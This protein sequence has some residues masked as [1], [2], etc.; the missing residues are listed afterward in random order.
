MNGDILKVIKHLEKEKGVEREN[1]FQAIESALLTASKKKLGEDAETEVHIDRKTGEISITCKEEKITLE[2]FGRVA[3][4]TAKQVMIQKIREAEKDMVFQEFKPTEGA[5]LSGMVSRFEH[6]NVILTVGKTEAILPYSE[7]MP[8]EE[9][10]RGA[11]IKVYVLEVKKVGRGPQLVV[12]RS[13]S[14]MIKRLFELEVPE[15]KEGVVEIKSVAREPGN[16]TKICVHSKMENVD[17]VGACV[18]VKGARIKNII[19]ELG[20]EKIDIIPWSEDYKVYI[21]NALNPA[22]ILDIKINKK[23]MSTVVSVA[24]EQL[25]LAIGK[26]GQN[27]RLAAKLTG[28]K[29]DIKVM[30]KARELSFLGISKKIVDKLLEAGFGSIEDIA[31]A[32]KK[33]FMAIKGIGKKTVEKILKKVKDAR[34]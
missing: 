12:S 22:R 4:Q 17:S 32:D 27:A 15:I 6:S 26:G 34:S 3:A 10:K 30:E 28:W 20:K 13:N 2:D 19:K 14:E 24:E 8:G 7:R 5:L 9:F 29:I 23:E 18:G 16:R 11:W 31:R 21:S 1:L 25:S 33:K